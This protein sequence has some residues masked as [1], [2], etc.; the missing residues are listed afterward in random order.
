MLMIFPPEPQSGMLGRH[1]AVDFEEERIL[2]H[3]LLKGRYLG[4]RH[5]PPQKPNA[6]T[7][8]NSQGHTWLACTVAKL[9]PSA[10]EDPSESEQGTALAEPGPAG[11]GASCAKVLC[12]WHH[13]LPSPRTRFS[14]EPQHTGKM[15]TEWE[16]MGYKDRETNEMTYGP[17]P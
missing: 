8:S 2:R 17:P 16:G 6:K 10:S 3:L 4:Q 9:A 15:A 12:L 11:V 13:S 1:W 7:A 5:I 14:D